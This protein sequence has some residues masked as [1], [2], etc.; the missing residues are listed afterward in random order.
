MNINSKINEALKEFSSGD[1]ETAYKKLKI[2]FDK[3]KENDQLRFNLAVIQQSL[4][5]N[6][7]AIENY[8]F[9]TKSNKNTKAMINLYLLYIKQE[10]FDE[11]T[12]NEIMTTQ[13]KNNRSY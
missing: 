10:N 1:K 11:A 3:N 9:L 2:I 13:T 5:L 6:E 4:N 12:V 8:K 7:D